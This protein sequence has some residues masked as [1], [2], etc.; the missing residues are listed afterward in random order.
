MAYIKNDTTAYYPKGHSGTTRVILAPGDTADYDYW[1]YGEILAQGGSGDTRYKFTGHERDDES[2]LD[3]MLARMYAS[4]DGRILQSD[5]M[6]G[7]YPHLSPYVY[8]ADNP[9]KFIIISRSF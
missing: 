1:P 3:Y 4:A 7:K 8:T 5:P 6:A 9:M 2:G